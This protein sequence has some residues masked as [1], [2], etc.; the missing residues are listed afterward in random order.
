M[1][2]FDLYFNNAYCSDLGLLVKEYISIP[3]TEEQ[4]EQV[5]I[6]G[7]NGS[8]YKSKGLYK[9][10]QF[11]V[12]FTLRD[13]RKDFWNKI[14]RIKDWLYSIS[15]NRFIYDRED[16]CLLVKKVIAGDIVR[17]S[18][19]C[20]K[21]TVTFICEPFLYDIEETVL[22]YN[23][24]QI[25]NMIQES[26]YENYISININNLG[27]FPV[28]PIIN[29]EVNGYISIFA[30]SNQFTPL[31]T[32]NSNYVNITID[33]KNKECNVDNSGNY[34]IVSDNLIFILGKKYAGESCDLNKL[35][36][37]YRNTYR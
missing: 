26:S 28:F 35:E 17:E 36:I 14:D 21:I 2:I 1:K 34:P 16:R 29:L 3:T 22:T 12:T 25:Q 8:I 33:S 23:A 20:G 24:E 18:R 7:R 10:K 4:Y 15:D 32:Y 37:K 11:D 31:D 6:I 9:D 13:S 5:D 27:D 30:G 19:S